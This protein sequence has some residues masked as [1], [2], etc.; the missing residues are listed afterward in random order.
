MTVEAGKV[1]DLEVVE[2]AVGS[3]EAKAEVEKA[4]VTVGVTAGVT[5]VKKEVVDLVVVEMEEE[6]AVVS[7][8]VMEVEDSVVGMEVEKEVADSEEEKEEGSVV[9]GLEVVLEYNPNGNDE[10]DTGFHI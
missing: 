1:E 4:G 9:E 3:V 6:T 8:V 2:K 5:V 7:V 10:V